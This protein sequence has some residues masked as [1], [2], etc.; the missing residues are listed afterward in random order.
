MSNA[1]FKFDVRLF[2]IAKELAQTD[3][4]TIEVELPITA[5]AL[6]N[7]IGEASPPLRTW[8]PSCRLAVEQSFVPADHVLTRVTDVALIPPV[9][10]G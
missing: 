2:A 6:M 4:L 9:S 10:G 3:C 8:L 1:L 7:A 5:D